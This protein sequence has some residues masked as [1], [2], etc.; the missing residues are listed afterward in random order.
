MVRCS[1]IGAGEHGL[2]LRLCR[3]RFVRTVFQCKVLPIGACLGADVETCAVLPIDAE[4]QRAGE[5]E[6][7]DLPQRRY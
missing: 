4:R 3:L 6:T 1:M 5:A 7:V 2:T